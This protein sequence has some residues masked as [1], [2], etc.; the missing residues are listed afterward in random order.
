MAGVASLSD[1][2]IA[3]SQWADRNLEKIQLLENKAPSMLEIISS[4]L[5][6]ASTSNSLLL[7]TED[8][9]KDVFIR[10]TSELEEGARNLMKYIGTLSF[11]FETIKLKLN[12]TGTYLQKEESGEKWGERDVLPQLWM[13]LIRPDDHLNYKDHRLLLSDLTVYYEIA[14]N[15]TQSAER[16]VKDLTAHLRRM[17]DNLATPGLVLRDRPLEVSMKMLRGSIER[18]EKSRKE[19]NGF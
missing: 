13:R 12:K 7:R 3:V 18:I 6:P 15:V 2:V 1:T 14:M 19:I 11:Q 17:R 5:L 10:I 16:G 8:G 9:L 4:A